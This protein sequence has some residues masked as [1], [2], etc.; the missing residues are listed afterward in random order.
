MRSR[1]V[2]TLADEL[3][4]CFICGGRFPLGHSHPTEPDA[5]IQPAAEGARED[6][7]LAAWDMSEQALAAQMCLRAS[8]GYDAEIHGACWVHLEA[9]R[10]AIASDW[11]AED[12]R[13]ARTEGGAEA[14][15]E[16]ADRVKHVRENGLPE[17]GGKRRKPRASFTAAR[18]E[19]LWWMAETGECLTRAAGRIGI[20]VKSLETWCERNHHLDVLHALRGHEPREVA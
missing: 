11:L 1:V 13:R 2:A 7:G 14:L 15:E 6:D 10:N 4:D 17:G 3:W 9:A 5:P 20:T 19:D 8:H 12:R 18:L 16:A